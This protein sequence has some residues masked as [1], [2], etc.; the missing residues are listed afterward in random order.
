MVMEKSSR[1]KGFYKMSTEERLNI[2][3]E[4]AELSEEEVQA[5]SSTGID[6]DVLDRMI[7]NVVGAFQLPLGI[8]T[9]FQINGKDYLVPMAG[10]E[11]SVVAAASNAAR[12]ARIHGGF[13]SESTDP[14]MIGQIQVIKCPNPKAAKAAI[15]AKKDELVKLA[16][17]QDPILVKFG[18]GAKDI[19]PR[20]IRTIKGPMVIVHILVDVRDAMGANAV[21]TMAEALSPEIEEI[22]GGV[23]DL[24]IISNLAVHRLS[25]AKA[26]FDVESLGGMRVAER[27][28]QAYAFAAADPYRAATHNKGIMNGSSAVVRA[29]GNDTRAVE[30][31]AH[32]YAAHKGQYTSLSRYEI[33]A[34][35]QLEGSIEMPTAVGLIGGAT[36]SHPVARAAIKILGVQTGKELGEIIA[37]VG[38]AQNFAALRALSDEGIQKGHMKLHAKNIAVM[39]GATPEE[40]DAVVAKLI[41]GGKVRID[42]AQ[43]ILKEMRGG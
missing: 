31:G 28:V 18:G 20:I 30:A 8:A 42:K 13:Q 35:G 6:R 38:L 15:L 9:N 22:T 16:N 33:N 23:V 25:R 37:C 5:I 17:E 41:E 24:K 21:N 34:N 43:D 39:A 4:F 36:K 1:I 32:A 10:E 40:L 7:E 3:K 14:V 29:T 2:V 11:P 19:K 12:M 27:I 26:I